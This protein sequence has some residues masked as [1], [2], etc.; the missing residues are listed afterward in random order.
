MQKL[1]EDLG[2]MGFL[3]QGGVGVFRLRC[4]SDIHGERFSSA[5][6]CMTALGGGEEHLGLEG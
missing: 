6:R 4:L 3:G 2:Q 5:V 1:G